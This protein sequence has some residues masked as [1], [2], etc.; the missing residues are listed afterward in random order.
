MADKIRVVDGKLPET[1]NDGDE[2]TMEVWIPNREATA[3]FKELVFWIFRDNDSTIDS[4]HA[5]IYALLH[6]DL[7][8]FKAKLDEISVR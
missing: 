4:I 3:A 6:T 2:A 5:A 7:D 8:S 1:I